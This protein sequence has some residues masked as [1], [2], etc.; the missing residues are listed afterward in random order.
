MFLEGQKWLFFK[1]CWLRIAEQAD[2]ERGRRISK[3]AVPL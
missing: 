3:I 2:F 1:N